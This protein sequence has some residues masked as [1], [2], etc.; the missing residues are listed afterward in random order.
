MKTA[1]GLPCS[2]VALMLQGLATS[3]CSFDMLQNVSERAASQKLITAW[4]LILP[5]FF[6]I[7]SAFSC[8]S[9]FLSASF[10]PN[11]ISVAQCFGSCPILL[12]PLG[13]YT[14]SF[15]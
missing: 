15:S 12:S 8:S 13:T 1:V 11:L 7:F 6:I 2:R 14:I 4:Q 10:H 3:Y 9:F 5:L